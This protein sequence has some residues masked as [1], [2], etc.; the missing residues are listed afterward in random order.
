MTVFT[1]T[2]FR[3]SAQDLVYPNMPYETLETSGGII[4]ITEF[5]TGFGAG[6]VS[7]PY[8]KN[9]SG[10]TTLVGSQINR[11]FIIAAGTGL[12][13]YDDGS[14]VPLFLDIRC[15]M[16]FSRLTPYLYADGGLLLNFSNL[17]ETQIF[18]N[19]GI[20]ASYS[21]FRKFAVNLSTGFLMQ[22]GYSVINTFI[23]LKMGV[24]C[25]F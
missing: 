22:T 17:D 24:I 14:L 21:V 3:V 15:K 8:S 1:F 11:S 2:L 19:P 6:D 10:F 18:M 13:I 7:V 16:N 20:G 12:S 9:F 5:Q 25:K 4:S 23:N